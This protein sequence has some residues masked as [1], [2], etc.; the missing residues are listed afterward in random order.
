ML[1]HVEVVNFRSLLHLHLDVPASY[2]CI[3]GDNNAGK[4]NIVTALKWLLD[5]AYANRNLPSVDLSRTTGDLEVRISADVSV[6]SALF[7]PKKERTFFGKGNHL[8]VG[9]RFVFAQPVASPLTPEIHTDYAAPSV[10]ELWDGGTDGAGPW[11]PAG[12]LARYFPQLVHIRPSDIGRSAAD[13]SAG[14]APPSSEE[15]LLHLLWPA[16]FTDADQQW[17]EAQ[18]A[19]ILA[20][21]IPFLHPTP[22]IRVHDGTRKIMYFDEY[23]HPIPLYKAGS[24][25]VQIVYTLLR[26]ALA[27][28]RFYR[29]NRQDLLLFIDEPEQHLAS[30]MQKS[31]ADFLASLSRTH[32]VIVTSHSSLF[33]RR[34]IPQANCL[35]VRGNANGTEARQGAGIDIA[36][37]RTTLG[38]TGEDSLYF[39]EVNVLVEGP[40]E[41]S[42]LPQLFGRL[43]HAGKISFH[44]NQV[45]WISCESVDKVIQFAKVFTRVGLGIVILVDNEQR[46]TSVERQLQRDATLAATARLLKIPLTGCLREAEFEDLFPRP[47]LVRAVDEHIRRRHGWEIIE[48]DL[49]AFYAEQPYHAYKKWGDCLTGMLLAKQYVANKDQ[50]DEVI[51]KPAVIDTVI[52]QLDT[53]AI[54]GFVANELAQAI[55]EMIALR[56]RP[57]IAGVP[58]GVVPPRRNTTWLHETN[59]GTSIDH[60]W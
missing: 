3:V 20:P 48:A 30:G 10:V 7:A 27:R 59:L 26:I 19:T 53:T 36:A 60:D 16:E 55:T 42:A 14:D 1:R 49:D 21:T 44:P 52:E 39:G 54:P 25:I 56:P 32:Q 11:M 41:T 57:V 46:S 5:P 50:V 24:G 34:D 43:Y 40:T 58:Q 17:I 38:I 6:P 12:S 13:S 47:M 8:R 22:Q 23:G 18:L 51:S 31:Y 9:R 45:T 37:I 4:S 29:H 15:Q 33:V 2:L 35:L 28:R